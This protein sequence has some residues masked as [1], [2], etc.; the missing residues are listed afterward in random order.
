MYYTYILRCKDDTL[1]TGITTD[2]ERR[3]LEHFEQNEKCAKY[4]LS[5]PAKKLE[6]VWRSDT[7]A[8]ASKLEY[9]IKKDL[10][11][12]QKELLI[13]NS[14]DL[15]RFLGDKI[16]CKEYRVEKSNLC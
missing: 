6:V 14:G 13:E 2:I 5:H 1:Y 4:T 12:R 7:K 11:K 15:K 16:S 3:M 9:H 10:T 8:L